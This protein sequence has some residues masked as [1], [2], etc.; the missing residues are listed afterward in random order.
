MANLWWLLPSILNVKNFGEINNSSYLNDYEEI[1]TKYATFNNIFIGTSDPMLHLDEAAY[2]TYYTNDLFI[3]TSLIFFILF[4]YGVIHRKDTL[5]LG[6]TLLM[7]F[8]AFLSKGSQQPF[9]NFFTFAYNNVFGFKMFRRPISKFYSI[10]W[11]LFIMSSFVVYVDVNKREKSMYKTLFSFALMGVALLNFIFFQCRPETMYTFSVPSYYEDSRI[12]LKHDSVNSVIVLPTSGGLS[13]DLGSEFNYYKGLD[14]LPS[15][16]KIPTLYPDLYGVS[17]DYLHKEILNRIYLRIA[18][19]E[20]IC[21]DTRD[22]GIT[23]IVWRNDTK[24]P[25]DLG[26]KGNVENIL[27]Y[28]SAVKSKKTFGEIDVYSLRDECRGSLLGGTGGYSP[29]ELL[30]SKSYYVSLFKPKDVATIRFSKNYDPNWRLIKV[31]K[32]V[33]NN[34]LFTEI[35]GIANAGASPSSGSYFNEWVVDNEEGFYVIY[36]YSQK[37]VYLGALM[38]LAFLLFIYKANRR[39]KSEIPSNI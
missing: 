33:V 20:D 26:I 9:G 14:I 2:A 4:I 3:I 27:Q 23:H 12:Y 24:S 1:A 13:P 5:L 6:V 19:S 8:F 34:S 21:Q 29:I 7:L 10:Y 16:W 39:L 22:L 11:L 32:N 17:P 37:F 36:Y 28:N 18:S 38:S 30:N 25:G 35:V 15:V 31:E